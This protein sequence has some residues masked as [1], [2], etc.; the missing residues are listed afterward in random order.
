M[1]ERFTAPTPTE[2]EEE[3]SGLACFGL[4]CWR[5][6]V[7]AMPA[8]H[9]HREMELNLVLSGHLDYLL[10][11]RRVT[12]QAGRLTLLWAA[13][14]HRLM[15]APADTRMFWLTLPLEQILAWGLPT[16]LIQAAL[17]G[18]AVTETETDSADPARF[19]SWADLLGQSLPGQFRSGA[20][21][22]VAL[23]LEARLLRLA[24]NWTVDG[25][26]DR[27]VQPDCHVQ[28]DRAAHSG[29]PVHSEGHV[30]A[31]SRAESTERMATFVAAYYQ[32]PIRVADVAA[33]AGL[34]PNYASG[35]FREVS[36]QS[37]VEHVTQYR[38]AHAQR[39]LVTG[40]LPILE[41]MYDAGFRSSSRFHSAFVRA[42]GVSPGQFR[43][44]RGS[45][46]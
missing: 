13:T 3:T 40:T 34:H 9:R 37:I 12:V 31:A 27:N 19:E 1:P 4:A 11:G 24:R 15:A 28:P 33:A 10:G 41:I 5:G 42:C 39:L 21:R 45:V 18:R 20:R 2:L 6:E 8:F 7:Q 38:V 16:G 30:T 14:P 32:R 44:R 23:E 43:R 22:I 17:A 25:Q 35:L 46:S 26:P 36:G 29:R